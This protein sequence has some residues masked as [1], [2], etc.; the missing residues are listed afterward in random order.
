MSLVAIATAVLVFV[1]EVLVW[2][3]IVAFVP[4]DV[5]TRIHLIA[6]VGAAIVSLFV[7]SQLE[8]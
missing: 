4:S 7:Y 8:N 5:G 1:F 3:Q 2:L 6:I